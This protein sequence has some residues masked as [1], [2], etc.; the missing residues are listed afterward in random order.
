MSSELIIN[1]LSPCPL[2]SLSPCPLILLSSPLPN[3]YSFK[4]KYLRS[5]TTDTPQIK[6]FKN[7]N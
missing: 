4:N 5:A 6:G 3:P 2:V 1:F 7:K